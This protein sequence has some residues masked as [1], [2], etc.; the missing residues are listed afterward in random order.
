VKTNEIN[1]LL[2]TVNVLGSA[3]PLRF[4]VR[5]DDPVQKV[6]ETAL[7]SYAR[8]GRLPV[9][10]QN[11]KLFELHNANSGCGQALD[12]FEIIGALGT[13]NFLLCKKHECK[14]Q[15]EEEKVTSTS[16]HHHQKTNLWKNWLNT[17]SLGFGISS[18]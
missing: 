4:L 6:M 3:G 5:Y 9:L 12:P 1:R 13:R 17:M 11:T 16:H 14:L 7:K 8:E 2:V 18:H 15:E 10:G